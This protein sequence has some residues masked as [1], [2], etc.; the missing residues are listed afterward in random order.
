MG[1]RPELGDWRLG[2]AFLVRA[3]IRA[4][5]IRPINKAALEDAQIAKSDRGL[6]PTPGHRPLDTYRGADTY[7]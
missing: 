2:S 3:P 7:R 1:P 5:V 4:G 6:T